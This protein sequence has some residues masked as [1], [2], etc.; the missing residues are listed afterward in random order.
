MIEKGVN[1]LYENEA[2]SIGF[3]KKLLNFSKLKESLAFISSNY[4]Y[5]ISTINQLERK[6][7]KISIGFV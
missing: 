6:D 1:E 2:A 5:L 4:F 7:L 3:A